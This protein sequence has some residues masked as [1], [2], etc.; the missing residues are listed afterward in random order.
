MIDKDFNNGDLVVLLDTLTLCR[1]LKDS[2]E[3]YKPKWHDQV[4]VVVGSYLQ[5]DTEFFYKVSLSNTGGVIT[6]SELYCWHPEQVLGL[7]YEEMCQWAEM[8]MNASARK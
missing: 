3:R 4:G 5:N 8:K 2:R 7:T 1:E 6:L